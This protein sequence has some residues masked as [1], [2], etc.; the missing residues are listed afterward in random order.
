MGAKTGTAVPPSQ[1]F[2]SLI[3][4]DTLALVLAGGK[5]TRLGALTGNRV[6]PAVPFGGRFRIV[7]FALSNCIN[8]GIRRIGVLTQ[9]KAHSL[10]QHIQ[11]GWNW[12][13][14]EFGEYVELLPAQQR[15]G[16]AWYAGTADAVR[17]NADIIRGHDPRF[18]LVLGGDHVYK[19]DYGT[20]L[21]FH[22]S[23]GAD[24]TVGCIPVPLE[25][26]H[27]FGVMQVDAD[28]RVREFAEKP[29]QPT[30]M[31]GAPDLA[32]ASMGIYV[33]NA[34][35]LLRRLAEDAEDPD[36]SHDFGHDILPRALHDSAV[37]GYPFL[38]NAS[39][40]PAYWRDVGDVDS[41]WRANMELLDVVPELNLY[42]RDWPIWTWQ[43]QTPPAKFVLDEPG[44][45]GM[46]VSSMVAGGCVISG[47]TVRHSMLFSSVMVDEDSLVEDS[48][49][50]PGVRIGKH[51]RVRRAILDTH[52][53]LPDHATIGYDAADQARYDVSAGGVTVATPDMLAGN[54]R[55]G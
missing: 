30:P 55:G 14:A 33:F 43:E 29:S 20:L 26:A 11:Q 32:L 49:L 13:R 36:S 2:V 34:A 23:R 46:A 27:A 18:V 7:D 16:E 3:T 12:F 17:Q 9:Y 8:S 4:R 24:I 40:R 53:V 42:D 35:Y 19:M 10:I 38:D 15:V 1:R 41:Y 48:I 6:K 37:Y 22:V 21:G 45:R 5:G 25:Q 50:L 51:C 54:D 47:A 31:P 52:C 28:G 44:R 39:G